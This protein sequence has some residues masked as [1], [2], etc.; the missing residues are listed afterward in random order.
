MKEKKPNW[1]VNQ[2]K[3]HFIYKTTC[4]VNQKFYYGMHS[5][6]NLDDGYLGSGTY[7]AKAIRRYGRDKFSLEILEFLPSRELLKQREKELITEET[8][9]DSQC[10]NLVIGGNGEFSKQASLAG[11]KTSRIPKDF[12]K[13]KI[14]ES[15]KGIQHSQDRINNASEGLKKHYTENGSYWSGKHHSDS[16]KKQ[17]GMKNSIHQSGNNNSQFGTCW[18]FSEEKKLSKKINLIEFDS[19][20]IQ[21]WKRGRKMRFTPVV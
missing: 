21:G 11:G 6:D 1:Y 14:S 8:L 7:L 18:I 9:K 12:T 16:A 5:T 19:Y 4:S 13:L 3:F 10:M 15:L 2:R 20:Q 17:I